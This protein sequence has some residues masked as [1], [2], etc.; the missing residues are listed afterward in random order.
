MLTEPYRYSYTLNML[1]ASNPNLTNRITY[2]VVRNAS[3]KVLLFEEDQKSLDD[4]NFHPT[5]TGGT[6]ENYLGVRHDTQAKPGVA[7]DGF[8]GN[9]AFADGHGEAIT[10]KQ[11]RDAMQYDPR[12]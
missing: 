12:K 9:V 8:K 11:S 2:A 3:Q 10:R 1:F 6:Y 4:G 5:L 7:D